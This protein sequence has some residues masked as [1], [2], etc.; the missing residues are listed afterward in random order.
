MASITI[1]AISGMRRKSGP[2]Q[3]VSRTRSMARNARPET[4]A[5]GKL[6]LCGRLP[7]RR[8]VRK[9]AWPTVMIVWQSA[10]AEGGH[11]KNVGIWRKDSHKRQPADCQSAAGCQPAPHLMPPVLKM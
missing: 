11:E 9:V 8:H 6:R 3:A 5:E 4:I 7:C 1:F 10:A 2:V